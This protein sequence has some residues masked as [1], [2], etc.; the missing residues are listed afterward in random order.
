MVVGGTSV[1][2]ERSSLGCVGEDNASVGQ[3]RLAWHK[4]DRPSY[5]VVINNEKLGYSAIWKIVINIKDLQ[6]YWKRLQG[7]AWDLPPK[8]PIS[9]LESGHSTVFFL[10]TRSGSSIGA[11]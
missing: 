1:V 6:Q 8:I 10:Y 3:A 4:T 2:L 11:T 5:I 9:S 7:K